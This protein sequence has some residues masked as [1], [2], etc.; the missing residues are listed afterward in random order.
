MYSVFL[1]PVF[2]RIPLLQGALLRRAPSGR[3][4]PS[5]SPSHILHL[6]FAFFCPI[7]TFRRVATSGFFT[8]RQCIALCAQSWHCPS[9]HWAAKMASEH[10]KTIR[11]HAD[12]IGLTPKDI[13]PENMVFVNKAV[14][15]NTNWRQLSRPGTMRYKYA[16]INIDNL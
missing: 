13:K 1:I 12:E 5:G 6:H 7:K 14:E 2:H 10:P 16:F 15:L 8:G 3:H 4:R 11:H 9:R